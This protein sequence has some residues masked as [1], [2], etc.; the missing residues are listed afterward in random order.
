MSLVHEFQEKFIKTPIGI[1]NQGN[2]PSPNIL[3]AQ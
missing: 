3:V 2:L 1:K